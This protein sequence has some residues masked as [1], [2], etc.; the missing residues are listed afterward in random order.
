MVTLAN[1]I[2]HKYLRL[3]HKRIQTESNVVSWIF[4]LASFWTDERTILPYNLWMIAILAFVWLTLT[5]PG[6]TTRRQWEQ[7]SPPDSATE[8]PVGPTVVPHE[9]FTNRQFGKQPCRRTNSSSS[10]S[11]R[12]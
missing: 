1:R 4:W 6:W 11:E 5:P 12:P 3:N 8:V 9:R 7:R 2:C 10:S